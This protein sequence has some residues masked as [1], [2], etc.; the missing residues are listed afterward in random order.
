MTGKPGRALIRSE[1]DT[2]IPPAEERRVLDFARQAEDASWYGIHILD[3]VVMGPGS[4]RNGL[5]DNPRAFRWVGNQR[6]DQHI[7]S[8]I[9]MLP[10]IAAVTARIRLMAMATLAPL[11]PPLLNAKQW[12]ALGLLSGC[13]LTLTPIGG[14]QD[15]EYEAVGVPST[16]RG[17]RLDEQLEI[18]HLAWCETPISYHGHYYRFE[19]VYVNPKPVQPGGSEIIIG[20]DRLSSRMI[21]PDWR[22]PWRAPDARWRNSRRVA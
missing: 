14:W 18:M 21:W 8:R 17:A 12:A 16:E 7:P 20:G 11:R 13:R 6:P 3:R 9:V 2:L 22:V 4:A 5:P 1:L 19:N 10:A 15:E